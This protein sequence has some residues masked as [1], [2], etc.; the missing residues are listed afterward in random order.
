M[1]WQSETLQPSQQTPWAHCAS[2]FR[3][4]LLAWQQSFVHS[5]RRMNTHTQTHKPPLCFAAEA[6]HCVT[7]YPHTQSLS[8][9]RVIHS[10]PKTTH[11][12]TF[13]SAAHQPWVANR[14]VSI[15]DKVKKIIIIITWTPVVRDDACHYSD[16]EA[17]GYSQTESFYT[18]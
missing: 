3:V 8:T 2:C 11:T 17:E 5:C 15:T 12:H 18:H 10:D 4:Q 14:A 16:A 1:W 6:H 9:S 13:L 7:L